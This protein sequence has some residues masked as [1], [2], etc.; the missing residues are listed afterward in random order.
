MRPRL[1]ILAGTVLLAGLGAAA[2]VALVSD[3]EASRDDTAQQTPPSEPSDGQGGGAEPAPSVA[4]RGVRLRRIGDFDSPLFVTAPPGDRRRVFVVE[5]GGRIRLL[6]GGKRVRRPFLDISGLVTSGGEQGLLSMAFAPDYERSRRFYVYF[7]DRDGDT[8]VQEFLRSARSPNRADRGSRRPV[9]FVDQPFDNHNGGLLLFGPDR[10][11]YVGLGDG[12]SAG[13]PFNNAQK[14]SNLL[15]KILR[16][17]PRAS[18]TGPYSVPPS[19][20]FVGRGGRDEIYAYGLRNPWRF[21]F[22]AANGDL[23]IGDVGQNRFEEI[24][25]AP[26]GRALG[27]NYGWSCFEGR[28]RFDS[29]R[30]CPGAVGPVLQYGR[31]G[32]ACSVTGGVVVRDP[33]LP[34]LRGRYLYGDFCRGQVRAFRIAGGG[35]TGDRSL[36]LT[37]SSLS[38]FG[39]DARRRV[40][41]TSLE[42]PVYRLA[43]R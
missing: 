38:S 22:D 31:G 35:A 26:R 1:L 37:V 16:I 4:R 18:G 23:Y 25:Y 7:T 36:G 20:P 8:R 27:R 41:L 34:Q 15:G 6:L 42:G 29:S 9:L 33:G 3:G 28:S 12:G 2:V 24:D 11:L 40:Y 30:N 10:N 43:S 17:E 13:D 32:G 14:T 5:Q 19:N 39:E 21:S